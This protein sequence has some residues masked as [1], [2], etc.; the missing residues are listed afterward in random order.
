MMH[1]PDTFL[2]ILLNLIFLIA[3]RSTHNAFAIDRSIA[4]DVMSTS[5]LN[6]I[7]SQINIVIN[8]KTYV[9]LAQQPLLQLQF[10][11]FGF[12]SFIITRINDFFIY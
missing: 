8:S 1:S 9:R 4:I 3:V 7:T 2:N 11:F 6:N 10:Y 5:G 12:K